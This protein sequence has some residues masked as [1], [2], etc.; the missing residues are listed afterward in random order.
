MEK[1]GA[2]TPAAADDSFVAPRQQQH[3]IS[4]SRWPLIVAA[5]LLAVWSLR[6]RQ[7][8]WFPLRDSNPSPAVS[9]SFSWDEV[10]AKPYLDYHDCYD[11]LSEGGFKCARLELP[12]DYWNGTTDATVSIAILKS[13]AAVPVTHPKYGGPILLN[14]GGPGGSGTSFAVM[15]AD[16]FRQLVDDEDGKYFDF[17]GFDPRGVGFSTPAIRCLDDPLLEQS[18]AVRT[19]EEG[20]FGASD[21]AFGRLWSIGTA[22]L[23]S[24]SLPR[25]DG[26]AD[27]RKYASTASVARDMVEI[28]ERHGEWREKEAERLMSEGRT[29]PGR[30][31]S[32]SAVEVPEVL[33]H[34]VGKE[35]LNYWGFSYGTYLVSTD[36]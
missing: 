13:P 8:T 25:T 10:R 11:D 23:K 34:H 26:E 14:P 3:R 15:V 28:V 35:K 27:I 32:K 33:K 1:Q 6:P 5:L 36:G 21:A 22:R 19:L 12:M 9:K 16:A 2:A 31:F 24:C 17:I 18:W 30:Q 7:G 29:S 4:R 20:V